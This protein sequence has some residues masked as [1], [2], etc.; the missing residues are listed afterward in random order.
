MG[1]RW[2]ENPDTVYDDLLPDDLR[3][4]RTLPFPPWIIREIWLRTQ[5]ERAWR[6]LWIY[7][8]SVE[9]LE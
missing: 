4:V 2:Q 8:L 6:W 3:D 7:D 5:H 1:Y 9:K